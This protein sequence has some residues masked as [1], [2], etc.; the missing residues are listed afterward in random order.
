[1]ALLEYPR[2]TV[3]IAVTLALVF[4]TER[5]AGQLRERLI[6]RERLV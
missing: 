3:A 4:L 5:L 2:A 1:M 6:S